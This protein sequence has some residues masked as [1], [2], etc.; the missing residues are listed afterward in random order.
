MGGKVAFGGD[1]KAG[2]GGFHVGGAAGVEVAGVFG[3]GKRG[4]CPFGFI[5]RGDDIGVPRKTKHG[6]LAADAGV[7]IFGVAVVVPFYFETERGNAGGDDVLAAVVVWGDAG[8][9]EQLFGKG[10][11][12]GGL[13]GGMV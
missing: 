8:L 2:D 3:G 1:D 10:D 12:H 6:G 5:A 4:E 9:G 13:S 11:G 7:E